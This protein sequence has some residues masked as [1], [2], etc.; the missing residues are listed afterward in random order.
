ME[1]VTTF[2]TNN[3]QIKLKKHNASNINI[4]P[5]NKNLSSSLSL[6]P[7]FVVREISNTNIPD[8]CS[9]IDTAT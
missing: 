8:A 3:N 4:H 5:K 1:S 2:L 9:P 6:R 7:K